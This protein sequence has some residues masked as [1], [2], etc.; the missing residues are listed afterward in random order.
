MSVFPLL[1][2]L[3]LAGQVPTNAVPTTSQPATEPAQIPYSVQ[4]DV[5]SKITGRT[6]RIYVQRPP[7]TPPKTGWP[8]V[9]ALDARFSFAT[10]SDL[11]LMR[12]AVSETSAVV[13]GIGYPDLAKTSRLRKRDMFLDQPSASSLRN[14]PPDVSS[15]DF[16]GAAL[17]HRFMIEELRPMIA[18]MA[19]LDTAN[20]SL[21]GYSLGAYFVM[22]EL[23]D[24]PGEYRSYVAGSP[25]LWWND[26]EILAKVPRFLARVKAG[27][28]APRI[29]M[30]VGSYEQ[31]PD[32]PSLPTSGPEREAALKRQALDQMVDNARA[33]VGQ[34]ASVKGT[35]SYAVQ[36]VLF[37]KETHLSAIPAA[38]SRGL[39]FALRP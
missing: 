21:I 37:D 4:F 34:L 18:A 3:V 11:N 23:F 36:F 10:L 19:P 16:G 15:A 14:E 33:L 9:Y 27:E 2:A 13:V 12:P 32:A 1:A 8:V 28:I 26:R 6:Y 17:F 5:T 25:I 39:S 31:D 22:N 30:T 20:Q 35:P 29:L 7:G 38:M 24:H